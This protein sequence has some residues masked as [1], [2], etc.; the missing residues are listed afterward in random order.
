MKRKYKLYNVLFPVWMLMMFPQ[1]WL[2]VI[3]GNFIIDS[4][5][6]IISMYVLKISEKKQ[7]YKSHIFKIFVFGLFADIIGT[8][9][10]L[11]MVLGF[12]YGGGMCD[13]LNLTIPAV[14]I[15]AVVIFLCDY[16]VTFRECD[17]KLRLKLALTYAIA[18]A[19]YTFLIPS[20]WIY[21]Y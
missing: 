18:T 7:M 20:G 14:L 11:L 4:L 12:E 6:L 19:P 10:M 1:M 2:I 8:A 13:D 5:V 21:G 15:S 17:K 9:F 3:P 16:F